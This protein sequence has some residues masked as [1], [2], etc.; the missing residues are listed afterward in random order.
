MAVFNFS[1][2]I[3]TIDKTVP[4]RLERLGCRVVVSGWWG[5]AKE[6]DAAMKIVILHLVLGTILFMGRIEPP[7]RRQLSARLAA[8]N[9]RS[10]RAR[11]IT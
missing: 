11:S 6:D 2:P 10:L 5:S 9:L 4:A 8:L 7:N 1:L 3:A